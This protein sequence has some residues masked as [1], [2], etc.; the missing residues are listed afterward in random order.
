VT[1]NAGTLELAT[2]S[3]LS[4]S[5]QVQVASGATLQVSL[6]ET[7]GNLSGAGN[8]ELL[9]DITLT[10]G[11][12][13]D[14]TFSGVIRDDFNP[15][16]LVKQ[17]TGTLTLS[18]ANTYFGATTVSAGTLAITNGSALGSTVRGTTVADGATL[19][20]SGGITT[21][22]AITLNGT[23]VSGG[24]A[25]RNVSGFNTVTGAITLGSA[26]RINSDAGQLFLNGI[27]GTDT[28]LTLGGAG[29]LSTG[30]INL[31]TGTLTKDGSGQIAIAGT[32]TFAAVTVTGGILQVNN[33]A[34]IPDAA[35]VTLNAGGELL[36]TNSETIGNLAGTGDVFLDAGQTLTVDNDDDDDDD[37][38]GTFGG[39]I[40]NVGDFTKT[41]TGTLTL[42]GA[43]TY[44]GTTTVNAGTLRIGDG[45]TTGTLGTGNVINNSA[46]V[47]DRSNDFTVANVISGSG[48]VT[49]QGAGNLTLSGA[50]TYTG[51]TT[52]NAGTLTISNGSALGTAAAGTTVADGATLALSGGITTGEPLTLNG[53]GVAGGGAL[54]N[55]SGDNT[56]TGAITLG[57]A[58]RINSDAGRMTVTGNVTGTNTNLTLGGVGDILLEGDIATGTGTLTKDGTG[59]VVLSGTN[60]FTGAVTVNAG[61]LDLDGGNALADSVQVQ[62]ASGATLQVLLDETIGNLSGAGNVDLSDFADLIL[63]DATDS[64]F[65]GRISGRSFI[66]KQGTGTLTLSGANT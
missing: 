61:S 57:S 54:R 10:L 29:N 39:T 20:L 11:D 51:L 5:V 60:T 19:A 38:D 52:V 22:E 40:R 48:T 49:K 23:G 50:N 30:A 62:V 42:S 1:V 35:L 16:N 34:A 59:T 17:G 21:G 65:S 4:D 8:V 12:A 47:F 6:D 28:N 46:L 66:T 9:G 56:V 44:T 24:G 33:G 45:G 13:T 41:G 7:I 26:T 27:T 53:A 55:L 3:D 25:L 36:V 14:S 31:G 32:G 63:G 64:A 43:N 58:T 37:D 18:G 15:G 2:S